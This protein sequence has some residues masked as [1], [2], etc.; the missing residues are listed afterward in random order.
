MQ[1]EVPQTSLWRI[2]SLESHQKFGPDYAQ[3][4]LVK[5][6]TGWKSAVNQLRFKRNL[7]LLTGWKFATNEGVGL[8]EPGILPLGLA[9]NIRYNPKLGLVVAVFNRERQYGRFKR[10][11]RR[12]QEG[13]GWS[14]MGQ[15]GA[16]REQ[17]GA[18]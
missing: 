3:E 17:E 13:A 6:Q 16:L 18:L 5:L 1:G 15:D 9:M 12:G 10:E 8:R 4:F 14:R 11:H 2:R 7:R